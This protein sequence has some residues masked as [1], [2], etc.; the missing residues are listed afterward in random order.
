MSYRDIERWGGKVMEVSSPSSKERKDHIA[1]G[2]AD[3]VFDE[4]VKSWGE[5][6]SRLG[7]AIFADQRRRRAPHAKN[8]ASH[9][10]AYTRTISEAR[11]GNSL[12]RF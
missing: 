8:L 5:R 9:R 11:A 2:S 10:H 3:A 7:D 1:S 12:R 6:A 4:G